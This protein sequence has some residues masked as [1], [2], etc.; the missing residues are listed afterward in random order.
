MDEI[1]LFVCLF[2]LLQ[3]ETQP[4]LTFGVG[5]S[6]LNL[7]LPLPPFKSV[8]HFLSLP[9]LQMEQFWKQKV[10]GLQMPR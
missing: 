10:L 5:P 7:K 3:C 4:V 2:V 8:F 6:H 9:F 1:G